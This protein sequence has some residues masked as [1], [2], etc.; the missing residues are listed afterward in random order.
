MLVAMP[1]LVYRRGRMK[2]KCLLD[3]MKH[4]T[5]LVPPGATYKILSN[6]QEQKHRLMN[7]KQEDGW[8]VTLAM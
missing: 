6:V 1:V 3:V 2:E 5:G 7:W 4:Q 8:S